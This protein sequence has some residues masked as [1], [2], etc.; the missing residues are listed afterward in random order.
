MNEK[1]QRAVAASIGTTLLGMLI[2]GSF[3]GALHD[4]QPHGI[5]M[6]MVG[7]AAG[8]QQVETAIGQ[9]VPGAFDFASYTSVA[10]AQAAILHRQVDAAFVVSPG[11]PR[12]II[13]SA[14][15]RF[16]TEAITTAFQGVAAATRQ[17]LAIADIRPLPAHDLNGVSPLFYSI[18]LILPAV[19]FGIVLSRALGRRPGLRG[20]LAGLAALAAYSALL[21]AAATW[22][23]DGLVGALTGAP[24][25]LFGIGAFTAFA[26][27][28]SCAAVT[29]WGGLQAG[30]L[31][32]MVILPVGLPASGGPFG[33]N[34]PPRW[35]AHIGIGLPPGATMPAVRNIVY[36]SS[37][38]L[39]TPLLVLVIW[40][41]VGVAGLAW[42]LR[43][44]RQDEGAAVQ[45]RPVDEPAPAP[46]T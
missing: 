21:G 29:R 32:A 16:I 6:A 42:P 28:A 37:H 20:Q 4:P 14:G 34:F 44:R 11:H 36:F 39:G 8:V 9:H 13:A 24:L 45:T 17:P 25:E 43:R 3:L 30:V 41:A 18:A 22:V 15:G 40:A 1:I 12:L 46:A 26:V 35:Y 23:A 38:G 2:I 27:S 5:P 19:V 7:P 33:P 10:S 31:T